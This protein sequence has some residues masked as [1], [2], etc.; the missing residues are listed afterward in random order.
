MAH[1]DN[2]AC[3][4]TGGKVPADEYT[5][6]FRQE[7]VSAEVFLIICVV[8]VIGIFISLFFLAFNLYHRKLK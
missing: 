2:H 1:F 4:P 5:R 7:N 3:L 8:S 6:Q